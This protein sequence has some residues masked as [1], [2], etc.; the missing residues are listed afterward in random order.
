MSN[1]VATLMGRATS[2]IVTLLFAAAASTAWA[3]A[4][5]VEGTNYLRMNPGQPVETGKKIEVIEF[6]SYG[7]PHCADLEP[8]LQSWVKGLPPDVAFRRVPVMF[9]PR[10]VELAKVYYTLDALGE[11]ARL[12]PEVFIAVHGKGLALWEPAKFYDW[13]ATKG[14]DRKKVEDLYNSFTMSGR[15]NRAKQLA[16]AYNIQEVPLVVVDGKFFTSA[17]RAG[18]H[19]AMPPLLTELVNKARAE[20]PKS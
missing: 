13:A 20:R 10:W 7:C 19:A 18:S 14:L 4:S 17:A 16:Q 15:V 5:A 9:Q 1:G 3:Q 12:S 6:F 2:L 11:E 8:Y